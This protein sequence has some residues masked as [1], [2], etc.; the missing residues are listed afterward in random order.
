[1]VTFTYTDEYADQA[2]L[3][4]LYDAVAATYGYRA[5]ILDVST[6]ESRKARIMIPNPETKAEFAARH[7]KAHLAE[8]VRNYRKQQNG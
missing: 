5:E 6:A 3:A 8:I 4:E 1:M 7:I 2:A